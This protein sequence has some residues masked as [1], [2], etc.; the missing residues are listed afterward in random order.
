MA[1]PRN[2]FRCQPI[3][4]GKPYPRKEEDRI[5]RDTWAENVTKGD[6]QRHR[7]YM[8]SELQ[9][10]HPHLSFAELTYVVNPYT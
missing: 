8:L 5:S 2:I 1:K 6:S 9:R 10:K 7:I 3:L 4:D